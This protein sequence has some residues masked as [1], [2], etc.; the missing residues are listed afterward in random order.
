MPSPR[1]TI[2]LAL[3]E[4][5]QGLETTA[6]RGEVLPERVPATGLVILRDGDPRDPEVSLSPLTY[7]Y[8]HRAEVEVVVQG[9]DRDQAFDALCAQIGQTLH[10]DR[11]LGGLCDWLEVEA[12]QPVDLGIEG[13][14]SIKAAT[15]PV[16]LH[17]AC[18]DPWA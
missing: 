18:Q 17:Y 10:E 5:L 13:G 7:Y 6:L 1:E 9:G 2:L 3:F 11:T 8:Q 15:I 14:A 4:R 12:P 16:V